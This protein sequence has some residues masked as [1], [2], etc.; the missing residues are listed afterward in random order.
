MIRSTISNVCAAGVWRSF[1][2]PKQSATVKHNGGIIAGCFSANGNGALAKIDGAAGKKV[3]L[4][5]LPL[6]NLK[7]SVCNIHLSRQRHF[8][9]D[10]DSKHTA[11][12][13]IEWLNRRRSGS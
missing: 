2:S 7:H 4:E 13:V 6:E 11:K 12:V 1:H 9:H 8:Q 10:D 5:I 3:C